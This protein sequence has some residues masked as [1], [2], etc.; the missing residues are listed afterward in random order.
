MKVTVVIPHYNSLDTLWNLIVQLREDTFDQIIVLDDN[1]S[2]QPNKLEAEFPAVTFQY[3]AKNVGPGANR[4]RALK[5]V[6]EGV[7]WFVDSDMEVVS[8]NN[9]DKL[10]STFK[11]DANRVIGGL[12]YTKSGQEMDWNYGHE[13]HPVHDAR[14]EEL[15]TTLRTG[16][17]VTWARL[18]KNGW[19]YSWLQPGLGQ[20]SERIV[21]WVAEGSFA[22]P[23]ELF[24]QVGGYDEAFRYH[25]GQDLARRIRQ[26]GARIQFTPDIITRHLEVGIHNKEP[27]ADEIQQA[28]YLF[29]KKHWDMPRN[30]YDELYS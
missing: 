19:N 15:V 14:F 29:F 26:T 28:R 22:L 21:D 16:D 5:L 20:A 13:M 9:A 4:N 27:H 18:E 7:V 3:G 10:R 17:T 2:I 6:D 23:I 8:T 12:I 11:H 1:S 24:R 30:I 25:E